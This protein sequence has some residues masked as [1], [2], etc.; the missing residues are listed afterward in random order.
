MQR[1]WEVHMSKAIFRREFLAAAGGAAVLPAVNPVAALANV[2]E[3]AAKQA[4]LFPDCC[5]YSYLKY[6]KGGSLTMEDF[7]AKAVALQS[8]SVDITTYWLKSTEP[9]YVTSLRHLAFRNG[10]A[11]SGIAIRCNMC[12]ADASKRAE[13]VR[14]IQHWVDAADVLGAPHVRVFGGE[15]PPGATEKQAIDW[16]AA[17]WKSACD[18][19]AKKGITLGIETHS[20]IPVRA[21]TA[22]EILRRVDSPYAGINL[23]ISSLGQKPTRRCTQ[24]YKRASRMPRT[25][26]FATSSASRSGRLIWIASGGSR[27]RLVARDMC[28]RNTRRKRTPRL[29][30]RS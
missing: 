19:S 12:Q 28:Q 27:L 14:N 25:R 22:L 3:P 8:H 16:V 18:Y 20:A 29:A 11:L 1:R 2:P 6:F 21:S 10:L 15:V 24:T 17:A 30:C 7:I 9:E 4:R 5:A 23:D 26:I 13:E